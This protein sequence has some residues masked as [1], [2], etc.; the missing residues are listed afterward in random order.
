[1]ANTLIHS[2][3]LFALLIGF[4]PSVLWLLFWLEI[5]TDHPEPAR[6]LLTCF[7]AGGLSVFLAAFIQQGLHGLVQNP[8][9]QVI[10]WATIEEIVK[11]GVF[12]Y[13][14]YKSPYADGAL[15]PAIHLIVIALGF[16][17]VE[18]ILYVFQPSVLD[19][20]MTLALTGGLRFFGSTLLHTISS[21]F[22]G[23]MIG[24]SRK[25]LRIVAIIIGIAGAIFLHA[26]FNFFILRNDTASLLQ[27]YGYLWIAAIISHIILEK[28]RRIDANGALKQS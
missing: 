2:T 13:V 11:F 4:I 12:Y 19:S 14:A 15:A 18:N 1:M 5:D 10:I 22:I 3:P 21:C 27:I 26:T 25:K 24:I 16:A 8:D 23:I 7:L 9:T 17:A 20:G 28:L 6:L